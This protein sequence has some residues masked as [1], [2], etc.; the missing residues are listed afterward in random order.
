MAV[1]YRATLKT[2]RMQAVRDDIDSG[3]GA[4]TL[5]I[6][7]AGMATVLVSITLADPASTVAGS[8]LTL[9]GMPKSGTAGNTGTAAAARI[10]ESGGTVIVD[11][12]TVGLAATDVII[13]NTSINS[14]QTVNLTAGTI[15][16][17]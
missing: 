2:T 4:A 7:T 14:G 9:A 16:H 10:K 6:G 13:D 5:E 1:T 3:V 15:T 12:L 8:I 17:G 11:G